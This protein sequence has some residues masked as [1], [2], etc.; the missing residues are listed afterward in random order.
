MLI[1]SQ[2]TRVYYIDKVNRLCELGWNNAESWF[3]G[4]LNSQ[5]Y[6]AAP[7]SVI[8]TTVTKEQLKVYYRSDDNDDGKPRLFVAWVTRGEE[9]WSRRPIMT[10]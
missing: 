5:E 8:T 10:F 9:T 7:N 4:S 3:K 2:K 1:A 6:K